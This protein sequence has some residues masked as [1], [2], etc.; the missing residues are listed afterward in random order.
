MRRIILSVDQS[1]KLSRGRHIEALVNFVKNLG[2]HGVE[3]VYDHPDLAPY[4]RF[5]EVFNALVRVCSKEGLVLGVHAPRMDVNMASAIPIIVKS[6][7][8]LVAK[9]LD[10]AAKHS[11]EYVTIHSGYIPRYLAERENVVRKLTLRF[12][13]TLSQLAKEH[14]T[15]DVV[16]ENLY[17]SEDFIP[18]LGDV[19]S[20]KHIVELGVEN[21]KV[22]LDLGHANTWRPVKEYITALPA[23]AVKVVRQFHLHENNGK[24]DQHL[25]LGSGHIVWK[26]IFD[27]AKERGFEIKEYIIETPARKG[28]RQ[29]VKIVKSLL[30]E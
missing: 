23:E 22:G 15:V 12:L 28:T 3:I 26:D 24:G 27:T 30:S 20:I 25:P 17:K 18:I 16:V 10:L 8:K 19:E 2:I 7:M 6:S 9:L 11:I 5:P 4:N 21:V 13:K 1:I 29:S 14:N